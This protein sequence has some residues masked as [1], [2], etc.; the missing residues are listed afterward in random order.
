MQRQNIGAIVDQQQIEQGGL[1]IR[2]GLAMV[3]LA[4]LGLIVLG[5]LGV[6]L[7]WAPARSNA[8]R[9]VPQPPPHACT[10]GRDRRR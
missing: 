1:L 8:D 5:S 7:K 9:S 3:Q 6:S 4:G 10:P 2:A